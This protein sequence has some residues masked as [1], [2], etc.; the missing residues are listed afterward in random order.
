MSA[1]VVAFNDL[2]ASDLLVDA[3]YL[4]GAA[5]NAADD[6]LNKLMLC[7][8]MGGFRKVGRKNETKYVVLYSSQS[9]R[10]WPDQLD[11]ATGLFTYYGDNKTPGS[12][13]HHTTR[14]GNRLLAGVFDCVHASPPRRSEVSPFFIFTKAP[15][16]GTRAVQFRGLAAPGASGV[17]PTDDLV[18]VWK[19]FEGQRFQNYKALFTI[20]KTPRVPRAWLADLQ[21][22]HAQS[23][24]C[25]KEWRQWVD[26]G[27]YIP[28]AA[29]PAI[30]IRTRE[31][32][33]PN[34]DLE[35]EI[36]ATVYNYFKKNPTAFEVCAAALVQF[37]NPENYIIDEITRRS[38]D[39]GR[40][41]IGRYRLGPSADPVTVDFALEAKCY[42]PELPGLAGAPTQVG[43]KE[44]SRLI[45]RLRHRQFGILVT[46]S[47]IGAQAYR[48]I[49]EDKHPVIL[50]CGRDLA[51][52]LIDKGYSSVDTVTQWLQQFPS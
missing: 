28:L 21:A 48:E 11:L 39:G 38:V 34:N 9:D 18:A 36:L 23:K 27:S 32:Q 26:V 12:H 8:N 51:K 40:D 4:G 2:P 13:L 25:P 29:E 44:T 42:R 3:V 17:A 20:L 15:L 14:G 7:G 22:G 52:L 24:S 16:Y 30:E 6:P 19:S 49:R 10:N 47:Y 43:V 45:S 41:A 37:Q 31:E 35:R 33:L 1:K 50:L 5:N 46:T